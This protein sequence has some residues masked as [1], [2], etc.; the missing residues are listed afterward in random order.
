[1]VVSLQTRGK[2]LLQLR[3]TVVVSLQTHGIHF[4][5]LRVT[6]VVGAVQALKTLTQHGVWYGT[7]SH[8]WI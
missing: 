4:L 1:M 5:Q 6:A 7:I 3:L 8:P 2:H